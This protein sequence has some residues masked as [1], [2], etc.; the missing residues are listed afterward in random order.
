MSSVGLFTSRWHDLVRDVPDETTLTVI[1]RT[2]NLRSVGA[3]EAAAAYET[4]QMEQLAT[5]PSQL[6]ALAHRAYGAGEHFLANYRDSRLDVHARI[7]ELAPMSVSL[8]LADALAV[9]GT[10]AEIQ[11]LA[12]HEDVA[13]IDVNHEFRLPCQMLT[14][15]EDTPALVDGNAWGVA[16]VR[17]P[18]T[19]ARY[20][21]GAGATV[22]VLDTGVDDTHP[23]LVNKVAAFEEFDALGLPRHSPVH[24]AHYHGTHVAGTIAGRAFR[25]TN[26]G[27][28]PDASLVVGLVMPA[29]R[30]TFAQIVA[31]MQWALEQRA[32]VIN[33]P[34]GGDI[35]SSCW[36]LPL[37]N[38][39][40]A[41]ALV[42][43]P[44]G[45]AGQGTCGGPGSDLF[46]LAVGATDEDDKVA[47]FSG[48]RA[49]QHV[50]HGGYASSVSYRKPDITAPGVSVLSAAPKTELIPTAGHD[51][52]ALSGTAL[53]A[54]HVAGGAALV[55]GSEPS[56]RGNPF[57]VREICLGAG[58]EAYGEA[59][60]DQRFGFG[61]LDVLCAAQA[62]ANQFS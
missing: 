41:G 47:A 54:G 57:A 30:G 35:Y 32:D 26:I 13:E 38:A 42:V 8:W 20:G 23:A 52:V 7:A 15:L 11:D 60:R 33:M 56:L 48:G 18:D 27:I 21:R 17:A 55:V 12:R 3:D 37:L 53:A 59:G 25:G 45:D 24:D 61:R 40:L 10:K 39:T 36:N 31:G 2:G 62:A 4:V 22:A 44:V 9:T 50:S 5:R 34:P 51:L 6:L 49:L 46:A 19:W 29:G 1:V 43:G 16:K 58:R 14:P 28:A